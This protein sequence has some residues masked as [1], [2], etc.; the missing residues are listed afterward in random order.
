MKKTTTILTFVI[1]C[2]L[3]PKLTSAN[4]YEITFDAQ[5]I[6]DVQIIENMFELDESI[7]MTAFNMSGKKKIMIIDCFGNMI[8]QEHVD[9][10]NG[11]CNSATL[12]PLIY[13]CEFITEINGSCYYLL[14]KNK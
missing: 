3:T 5:D 9:K 14:N 8:R 4:G 13:K 1:L 12:I 6:Y 7:Q 11:I 10:S 2:I